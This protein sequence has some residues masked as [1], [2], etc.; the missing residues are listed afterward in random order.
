[1]SSTSR[2]RYHGTN[3]GV[4]V[5]PVAH[6]SSPYA[7]S[8]SLLS[9]YG[10]DFQDFLVLRYGQIFQ[11]V[12]GPNMGLPGLTR[13]RFDL[14]GI[15]GTAPI[16]LVQSSW[17]WRY[18]RTGPIVGKILG[19]SLSSE[20]IPGKIFLVRSS[21]DSLSG[22]IF[23]VRPW[24][25][26]LHSPLGQLPPPYTPNSDLAANLTRFA[27]SPN[28]DDVYW[29]DLYERSGLG[30]MN[31]LPGPVPLSNPSD[32]DQLAAVATSSLSSGLG[33]LVS[34]NLRDAFVSNAPMNKIPSLVGVL[35]MINDVSVASEGPPLSS[36]PDDPR[37]LTY[38]P[39][40]ATT[41]RSKQRI[42]SSSHRPIKTAFINNQ[43]RDSRG[44]FKPS[45]STKRA[46][47]VSVVSLRGS[48]TLPPDISPV[49]SELEA[50]RRV[51][52][53]TAMNTF[54]NTVG[55]SASGA[56]PFVFDHP[57]PFDPN[58]PSAPVLF[59]C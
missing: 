31:K 54:Q 1:M 39:P 22:E 23:S 43:S 55:T 30:P 25:A 6:G 53:E 9:Q 59:A 29:L 4:E 24:C 5:Q 40:K 45:S 26:H 14:S 41:A 42:R 48:A 15:D 10:T 50:S 12:L 35:S 47:K 3:P 7:L 21:R 16:Y 51:V 32:V 38:S 19:S 17:G 2:C 52:M 11:M 33:P 37:D 58:L 13:Y 49:M 18:D 34:P 36:F 27:R 28:G 8:G 46:P 57:N 20:N 56:C 44:R